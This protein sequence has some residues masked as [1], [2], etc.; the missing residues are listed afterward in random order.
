[1]EIREKIDSSKLREQSEE[2]SIPILNLMLEKLK[3]VSQKEKKGY[4]LFAACPNSEN[5]I[6]ASLHAA[7]RAN[8]P[9]LFAA[10][11]NQVDTDGGYTGLDSV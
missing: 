9:V 5:V 7:K 8:A 11:L 2:K 1:M 4:T 6:K 10:T 3:D